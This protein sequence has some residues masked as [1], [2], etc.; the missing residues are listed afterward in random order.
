[1]ARTSRTSKEEKVV[2]FKCQP[3]ISSQPVTGGR[4]APGQSGPMGGVGQ[5]DIPGRLGRWG[6]KLDLI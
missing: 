5:N 2:V 1:M 4:V 3:I 6:T